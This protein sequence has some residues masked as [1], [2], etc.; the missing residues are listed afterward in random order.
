M[1]FPKDY[2]FPFMT[3][4]SVGNMIR[5]GSW[6]HGHCEPFGVI[7]FLL[8]K[9]IGISIEHAKTL[10]YGIAIAYWTAYW[11][12]PAAGSWAGPAWVVGLV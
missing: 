12:A 6:S 2:R 1:T 5:R 4:V 3:N 10:V 11:I 9:K 7:R 8:F